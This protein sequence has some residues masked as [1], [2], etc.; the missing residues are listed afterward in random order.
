MSA[1]AILAALVLL[2]LALVPLAA[3]A[4]EAENTSEDLREEMERQLE[5]V[6]LSAWEAYFESVARFTEGDVSS[7]KELLLSFAQGETSTPNGL[8][9]VLSELVTYELKKAAGVIAALVA[10]ALVTAL[11]ALLTDEGIKPVF[12]SALCTVSAAMCA[13]A[14]ASLLRTAYSAVGEEAKLIEAS[15]P[16]MSAMLVSLGQTA[17]LSVFRPLTVF[18]I[19]AVVRAVELAALPL[20]AACGALSMVDSRS[21][22]ERL[23]GMEALARSLVKWILGLI[24]A[25]YLGVTAFRGMTMAAR[26]GVSIRTAKYAVGRL[27]PIVGGMVGETVDNIMGCALLIRNGAGSVAAIVL[28]A[29]TVRPLAVLAAG[30]LIFRAAAAFAAPFADS[31]IVRLYS[32]LGDSTALLFSCA[33]AVGVLMIFTIML[34]VASG[35]VAAGLW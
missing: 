27:V 17:T 16:I 33:A 8:F 21:E 26:D 23:K 35:G 11:P 25:F 29:L 10:A 31:R 18:L 19:G 1:K 14:F 28:V 2:A 4:E 30:S 5:E 7:I 13:G 3:L 22:N 20:S 32:G 6:D 12:A 24:S 34:F 15:A 9:S